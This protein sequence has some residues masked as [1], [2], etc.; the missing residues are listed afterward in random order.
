VKINRSLVLIILGGVLLLGGVFGTLASVLDL[1]GKSFQDFVQWDQQAPAEGFVPMVVPEDSV[2]NG[3]SAPDISSTGLPTIVG[4]TQA[5]G[6]GLAPTAVVENTPEPTPTR[7]QVI[8]DRIII[9]V[10]NL[11][12]PIVPSRSSTA[13][14]GGQTYDQWEAPNK[15]AVG[16]QTDSA[17]LGQV[18]NT[19]LDGHHNIDGKVFENLHLL[20]PGQII[21]LIGGQIE[22]NYEVVNVMILPE[23]DQPVQV[24]L[25]NARWILPSD[26][27]RVTLVTCWPATSNTHRLIVVA[28]PVGDAKQLGPQADK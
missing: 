28:K 17:V 19:V 26:D 23:R 22:Y 3:L 24:R 21:T 15:F 2:K 27:E 20:Q 13:K 4:P 11:D 14:I 5:L 1:F 16:W 25:E 6:T 18:G 7:I 8:P 9:P 10:I 12:A